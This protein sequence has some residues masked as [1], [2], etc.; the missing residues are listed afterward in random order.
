MSSA[1]GILTLPENT[2]NFK[3]DTTF[4][5]VTDSLRR[6]VSEKTVFLGLSDGKKVQILSGVS[7]EDLV[8]TN[9]HD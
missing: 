8:I 1:T 7:E 2:I 6:T 5:Y 4:V 9:Y 3:G